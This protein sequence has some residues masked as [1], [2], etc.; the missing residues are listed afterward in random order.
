MSDKLREAI[1]SYMERKTA[2][3]LASTSACR[4]VE[5]CTWW[6]KFHV[7]SDTKAIRR[8]LEKMER[9]GLVTSDRSQSNNTKWRLTAKE[10]IHG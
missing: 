5:I 10:P 4:P 8:E 7:D 1:V 6:L 2:E 9:E 3:H